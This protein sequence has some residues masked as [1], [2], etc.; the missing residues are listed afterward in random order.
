MLHHQTGIR[1]KGSLK[2]FQI[3]QTTGQDIIVKKYTFIKRVSSIC[4]IVIFLQKEYYRFD[5]I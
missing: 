1:P 5:A 2:L 4:L 3:N